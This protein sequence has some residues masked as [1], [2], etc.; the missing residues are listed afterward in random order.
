MVSTFSL[1]STFIII[2]IDLS[3]EIL[4]Y[5]A[6]VKQAEGV[7]WPTSPYSLFNNTDLK[8]HNYTEF[9]NIFD[10]SPFKL[11]FYIIIYNVCIAL[12]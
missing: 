3:K 11:G 1:T 6:N 7:S 12:V 9:I 2:N 5:Y 8:V 10:L 4:L